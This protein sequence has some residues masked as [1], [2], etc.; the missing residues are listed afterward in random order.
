MLL[1][2]YQIVLIP[3][4]VVFMV[5]DIL[6]KQKGLLTWHRDSLG[7]LV[8]RFCFCLLVV[9]GIA[10]FETCTVDGDRDVGSCI[11]ASLIPLAVPLLCAVCKVACL[12]SQRMVV[13][14]GFVVCVLAQLIV[15]TVVNAQFKH[16]SS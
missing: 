13:W 11:S 8:Q 12:K 10:L 4:I 9:I 6:V 1:V 7:I 2:V 3:T 15:L 14:T 5:R 16:S